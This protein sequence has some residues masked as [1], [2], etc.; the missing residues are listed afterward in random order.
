MSSVTI[1][2]LILRLLNVATSS[3][4]FLIVLVVGRISSVNQMN[5]NE[6]SYIPAGSYLMGT[7]THLPDERPAH[8]VFI[9]AL[10]CDKYEISV[11]FWEEVAQWAEEHGYQFDS[12]VKTAKRGP[13]WSPAPV[14]HP[15]LSLIHI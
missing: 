6:M 2:Q 7:D 1:S 9:S 3:R 12:R 4:L 14:K 8:F 11:S 13:S 10:Y 15:M 5:G